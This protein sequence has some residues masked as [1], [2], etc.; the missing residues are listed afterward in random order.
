[1]HFKKSL[2]CQM[3]EE[4]KVDIL[5]TTYSLL[6]LACPGS[7]KVYGSTRKMAIKTNK[8][9][10]NMNVS[11]QYIK[12]AINLQG[13]SMD[14][15]TI[16]KKMHENNSI[17]KNTLYKSIQ[18]CC[19]AQLTVSSAADRIKKWL[20]EDVT[21]HQFYFTGHGSRHGIVFSDGTLSYKYL[22]ELIQKK[23]SGM[24]LIIIDACHSGSIVN[25]FKNIKSMMIYILYSCQSDENSADEGSD[26]G[27]FTQQLSKGDLSQTHINSVCQTVYH[28]YSDGTTE[29]QTPGT[30]NNIVATVC[31]IL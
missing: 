13:C 18:S 24:T 19:D 31:V 4:K 16:T 1:M 23:G 12:N 11:K 20:N 7:G 22:S 30:M 3:A 15:A 27:W 25:S 14:D 29:P 28:E 8:K 5:N 2:Q 17:T 9:E 10:N 26:G 21:C 6:V